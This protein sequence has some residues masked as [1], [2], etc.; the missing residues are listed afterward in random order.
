MSMISVA[1]QSSKCETRKAMKVRWLLWPMVVFSQRHWWSKR[2]T[3]HP[4]RVQYLDLSYENL[5][6]EDVDVFHKKM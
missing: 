3:T 2:A 5:C 4:V 6:E 1:V